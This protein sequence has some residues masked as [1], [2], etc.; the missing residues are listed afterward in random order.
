MELIL[1]RGLEH[2]QKAVDAVS[3][4][5]EGVTITSPTVAYQN[6]TF[7]YDDT[8]ISNNIR[9]LQKN[10]RKDYRHNANP[11]TGTYL[12]ID[13]KMETDA[14]KTYAYTETI[15]EL[16]KRYGF[17]K[18]IIAVPSLLIKAGTRQFIHPEK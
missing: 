9:E 6:P 13:V 2:Q 15:Y 16:H 8:C 14:G 7:S 11:D 12:N 4:V 17:N 18:F 3:A 5:F 10:V 1:K